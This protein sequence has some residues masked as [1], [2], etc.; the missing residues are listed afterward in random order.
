MLRSGL[1]HLRRVARRPPATSRRNHPPWVKTGHPVQ[2]HPRIRVNPA[3]AAP[4]SGDAGSIDPS[5]HMRGAS[6][7]MAKPFKGVINLDI[8]DSVPDWGPYVQPEAPEGAP[9]VL[10]IVLD[11][12]GFSAMELLGRAG[13]DPEHQPARREGPDGTPVAHHRAVLADP[14]LPADRAQPH[15]QRDG[16]HQPRRERLPRRERPHP[17][18]VRHPRRGAGRAG[19]E[20]LHARQVAP[21]RRGRDEHGVDEAELAGRPRLRALL[22]L[23]RRGDQPVVSG[24]GPRQ[25]PGRA[26]RRRPEDGLPPERRPHRQ[27]DRVHRRRQGRSRRTSRSSCTSAPAPPTPRTTPRRSGSTSTGAGSTWAT[28]R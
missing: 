24:P 11:D 21:V 10:Y 25:P 19:L 1:V 28:R 3:R 14:V 15:H 18:R 27:G 22:R 7:V 5:Q 4:G 2:P 26:A 9:N 20:H 23:P 13:R 16:L 12:V 8:R 6:Q 17:P